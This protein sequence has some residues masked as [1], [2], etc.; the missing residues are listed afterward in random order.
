MPFD[1]FA[2]DKA[3]AAVQRPSLVNIG[4]VRMKKRFRSLGFA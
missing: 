2:D 1:I 4:Y 3:L